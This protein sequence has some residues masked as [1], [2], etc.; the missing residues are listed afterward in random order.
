MRWAN[1][2]DRERIEREHA[3]HE[4]AARTYSIPEARG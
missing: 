2:K 1:I 4:H 3:Q